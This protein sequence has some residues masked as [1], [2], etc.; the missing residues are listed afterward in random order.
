LEILN[1]SVDG[2]YIVA[3]TAAYW[4]KICGLCFIYF[5]NFYLFYILIFSKGRV[6]VNNGWLTSSVTHAAF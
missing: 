3:S 5:S 2:L 4:E 6:A 1:D